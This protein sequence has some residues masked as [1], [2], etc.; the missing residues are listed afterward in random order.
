MYINMYT[1][2]DDAL[3]QFVTRRSN[4]GNVEGELVVE[5]ARSHIGGL[6]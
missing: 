6:I 2:G 5:C 3:P 4:A 1:D